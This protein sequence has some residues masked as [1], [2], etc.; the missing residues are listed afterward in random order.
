MVMSFAL[1]L[2]LRANKFGVAASSSTIVKLALTFELMLVESKLDSRLEKL[3]S[4]IEPDWL[5][6]NCAFGC[7]CDCDCE[8]RKIC[9]IFRTL[10]LFAVGLEIAHDKRIGEFSDPWKSVSENRGEKKRL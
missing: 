8:V 4:L 3:E 6:L 10:F 1:L 9:C 2:L 7:G 5:S